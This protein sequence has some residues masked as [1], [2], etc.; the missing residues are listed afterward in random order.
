MR[1]KRLTEEEKKERRREYDKRYRQTK[2]YKE[3]LKKYRSSERWGEVWRAYQSKDAYKQYKKEYRE[4]QRTKARDKKEQM[5]H[6]ENRSPWVE[7]Q[8]EAVKT[9]NP[10]RTRV[11]CCEKH[12]HRVLS[13]DRKWVCN[14]C[15][16]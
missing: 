15:N 14:A 16:G 6:T 7:N 1:K 5:P 13:K 3:S 8:I 2:S 11:P 12:T 4:Q 10:E 9:F